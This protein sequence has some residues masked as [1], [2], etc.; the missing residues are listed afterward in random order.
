MKLPLGRNLWLG[1]YSAWGWLLY[2]NTFALILMPLWVSIDVT[3][4]CPRGNCHHGERRKWHL[5]TTVASATTA[6][7]EWAALCG[8]WKSNVGLDK[9]ANDMSILFNTFY[10]LYEVTNNTFPSFVEDQIS[11]QSVFEISITTVYKGP[12]IILSPLWQIHGTNCHM[13]LLSYVAYFLTYIMP[14][15]F[16]TT[17]SL[18]YHKKTTMYLYDNSMYCA[19]SLHMNKVH[20]KFTSL[21]IVI[22][23]YITKADID[24]TILNEQCMRHFLGK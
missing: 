2:A 7:G 19:M 11:W 22:C 13:P 12:L 9:I 4:H 10:M 6:R 18:A 20:R 8:K 17:T 14:H 24:I 21:M 23:Y 16:Y 5:I 1:V 15:I 3:P